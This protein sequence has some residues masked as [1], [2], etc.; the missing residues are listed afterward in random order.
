[1]TKIVFWSTWPSTPQAGLTSALP[2]DE[3]I[4]VAGEPDLALAA[5]AEIAFGGISSDRVAK[6]LAA[7]PKLRW[8]HTPAAGVDRL[9]DIP[10]FRARNIAVTNNSGSYDIQIAEHVI[11]FMFGAAKRLH[12]YRDQ[13]ARRE[14][15]DQEHDELRDQTVDEIGARSIGRQV[16]RL[17]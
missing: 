15:K 11:A 17:A 1:M 3:I 6:L 4:T 9:L 16:V 5:D 2:D 8:Y 12:L 13:Q 14:W 7:A 10:D